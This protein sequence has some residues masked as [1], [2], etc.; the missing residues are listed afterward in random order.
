MNR[1]KM[2]F[3]AIAIGIFTS[4]AAL[5][6]ITQPTYYPPT[7][8]VIAPL[9]IRYDYSAQPGSFTKITTTT[10]FTTLAPNP[11]GTSFFGTGF[12]LQPA[13]G[14]ADSMFLRIA[15]PSTTSKGEVQFL[16]LGDFG[17]IIDTG[18]T[19]KTG[20]AGGTGIT[21]TL[22]WA[23][24]E[25]DQIQLV[26]EVVKTDGNRTQLS[27]SMTVLGPVAAPQQLIGTF[28]VKRNNAV[29]QGA[30]V[31]AQRTSG[32]SYKCKNVAETKVAYSP[33]E[34]V[35]TSGKTHSVPIDTVTSAFCGAYA[36]PMSTSG[37]VEINYPQ[38]THP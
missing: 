8:R 15:P 6:D 31:W 37:Y 26:A 20:A 35:D 36:V 25:K 5:A 32:N 14:S 12:W 38:P 1:N 3:I 23:V 9:D 7:P 33:L 10:G 16:Y 21:C 30:R 4:G 34:L 18:T 19:C 11:T 28:W 22:P 13:T 29:F 2:T 24:H 27:A 17:D